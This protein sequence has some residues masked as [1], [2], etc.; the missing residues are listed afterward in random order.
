MAKKNQQKHQMKKE[1]S[2]KASNKTKRIIYKPQ[3]VA[4]LN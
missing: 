3:T 1:N 4:E 2:N